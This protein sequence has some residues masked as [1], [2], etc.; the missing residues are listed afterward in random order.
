MN[1]KI[2]IEMVEKLQQ[3]ASVTYE[4]AKDALEKCDGDILEALIKLEQEGKTDRPNGGG[5]YSTNKQANYNNSNNDYNYSDNNQQ[6]QNQQEGPHMNYDQNNQQQQSEFSKQ[7]SSLWQSFCRLV[8]KG[9]VNHFVISKNYEEIVRMPVNVLIILLIIFNAAA[10]I[11]L[12]I[13]LFFGFKY[14]FSGPDLH[15]NSINSV[16]DSA[17]DAADEIKQS[18]KDATKDDTNQNGPDNNNY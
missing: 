8:K 1:E 10:L 2:T 18:A 9:N 15:K 17:S 4:E 6:Q 5:A 11:L 12:I 13:M 14:S 3:R 7:A 16:M